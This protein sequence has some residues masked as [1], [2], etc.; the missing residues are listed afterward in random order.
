MFL[1]DRALQ[2]KHYFPCKKLTSLYMASDVLQGELSTALVH[3][4][5]LSQELA[6]AQLTAEKAEREGK[7]E[8][9]RLGAEI[10]ALRERLDRADAETLRA[11][12]EALRLSEQ[13]AALDREV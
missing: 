2:S 12:Q 4:T 13:L 11:R 8:G 7:Q 3:H 5:G 6:S 10:L 1:L 9:K